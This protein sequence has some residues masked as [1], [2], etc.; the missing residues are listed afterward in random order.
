MADSPLDP[1]I[2]DAGSVDALAEKLGVARRTVFNWKRRGVPVDVLDHV[3]QRTGIPPR[4]LR[5]DLAKQFNGS[6]EPERA[7]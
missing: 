5:P 1:A 3:S 4:D 2:K 6:S 7:A